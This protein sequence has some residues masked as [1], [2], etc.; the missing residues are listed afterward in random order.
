[1]KKLSFYVSE[2]DY[3]ALTQ[4]NGQKLSVRVTN[5]TDG[6]TARRC[7]E[8]SKPKRKTAPRYKRVLCNTPS[9][10]LAE[11]KQ[12]Y[13][14]SLSVPKSLG[15]KRSGI[16]LLI[17]TEEATEVFEDMSNPLNPRNDE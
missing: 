13:R 5:P 10:W 17:E 9:G 12:R 15:A 3:E 6:K 8:I 16:Q 4:T 14:L 7:L 2:A 1:M 11:T